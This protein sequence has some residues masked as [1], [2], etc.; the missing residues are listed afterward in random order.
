VKTRA[1]LGSSEFGLKIDLEIEQWPHTDYATRKIRLEVL[2]KMVKQFERELRE[3]L[4]LEPSPAKHPD[5][6]LAYVPLSRPQFPIRDL[7]KCQ[8]C[9]KEVVK[10]RSWHKFC[11]QKCAN[12]YHTERRAEANNFLKLQEL[13]EEINVAQEQLR[14]SIETSEKESQ[15]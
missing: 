13:Q 10:T 8:T 6:E 2:H 14:R 15:T 1:E 3:F 4:L 11:S 12:T 9:G 7:I 5:E